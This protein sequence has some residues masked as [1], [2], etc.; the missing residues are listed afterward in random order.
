MQAPVDFECEGCGLLFDPSW[1]ITRTLCVAGCG[2][3]FWAC[4]SCGQGRGRAP[5]GSCGPAWH[6][7]EEEKQ[8][9]RRQA[10]RLADIWRFLTRGQSPCG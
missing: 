2:R 1:Q 3:D 7:K 9:A 10:R 4:L 8:E 6:A 5:C